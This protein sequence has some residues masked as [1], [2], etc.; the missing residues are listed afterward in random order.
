VFAP[1]TPLVIALADP[2][3]GER[4][5][6]IACG[7]GVVAR[8]PAQQVGRTGTVIGL[9]LNPGMLAFWLHDVFRSTYECADHMAGGQ[10][11]EHA[12]S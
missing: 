9:N 12:F 10:R 1:W 5:L 11:D 4:V 2:R 6:D 7:T 3:P 8:L